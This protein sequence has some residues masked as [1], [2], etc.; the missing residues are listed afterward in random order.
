MALNALWTK[1][2]KRSF[3]ILFKVMHICFWAM[4]LSFLWLV[5]S[6]NRFHWFCCD[7]WNTLFF[8]LFYIVLLTSIVSNS[9][10]LET[11]LRVLEFIIRNI[12]KG[13]GNMSTFSVI[14]LEQLLK[15]NR[16]RFILHCMQTSNSLTNSWIQEFSLILQNTFLLRI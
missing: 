8:I 15:F 3:C 4:N 16:K 14:M 5:F 11:G 2:P 10:Q 1:T 9:E 6:N 12:T 13:I 7:V